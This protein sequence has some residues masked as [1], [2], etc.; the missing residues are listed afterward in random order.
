M[1]RQHAEVAGVGLQA[2]VPAR[3]DVAG[4]EPLARYTLSH[5][6]QARAVGAIFVTGVAG[7]G[8]STMGT[9]LAGRLECRFLEG[10]DYHG[11]GNVAKMTSGQPLTDD[12]RWPWLDALGLAAAHIVAA[13]GVVVASCSA[14]RRSYRE[15][16]R[17][18]LAG[19]VAFIQLAGSPQEMLQRLAAR[20]AHFMPASLIDSQFAAFEPIGPDEPGLQLDASVACGS[21]CDTF[22]SWLD[23]APRRDMPGSTKEKP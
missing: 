22:M 5:D 4:R 2:L 19:K 15:R 1:M 14:L 23:Q 17:A 9:A 6:M 10:D 20:T 7:C 11:P 13:E 3:R 12:D 18:A 8:K 16:L 21:N